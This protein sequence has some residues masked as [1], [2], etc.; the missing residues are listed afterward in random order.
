MRQE[1]WDEVKIVLRDYPRYGFYI[2]QI[3]NDK[4]YPY[5]VADEN[6]GGGKSSSSDNGG[7]DRVVV[8]IADDTTLRKIEF[9][10]Q[11]VE[12]RLAKSPEWLQELIS[13]MYFETRC[14][15]LRPASEIV[16][17]SW[18]TCKKYYTLFMEDL[19][20]DLGVITF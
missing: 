9:Q 5:R 16:G 8:S 14:I 17:K 18:Q 10:K 11:I 15:A 13:L 12:H 2:N 6:I 4:L 1:A 19:A 7:L 20:K 3:R